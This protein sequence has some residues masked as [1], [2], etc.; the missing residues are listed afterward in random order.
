M[1][2]PKAP[3]GAH[4]SVAGG[5]HRCLPRADAIG[6]EVIQV[7]VANTRAWALPAADP[8]GDAQFRVSCSG[9]D[10]PVFVHA[11]YLINFGSPS[12]ETLAR[13]CSALAFSLRRAAAV[14]AAGVVLHAGS[15]V[16]GNGWGTA[17][18]QVREHVLPVLD[19]AAGAPPLLV[20]PTAG[21]GGALASDAASLAAYLDAL[22][23]DERVGVCLDTCHMHAA[24]H[25]LSTRTGFSAALRAYG[26]AAGRGGIGL[27][28]ANDSRDPAGSKR[29][30]HASIGTGSIGL[31]PFTALFTSP[32]T[33]SVPMVV[34]TLDTQQAADVATLKKLRAAAD[35]R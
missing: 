21:G 14:G 23:R 12:A 18:S 28:H 16:L 27:V 10:V 17:M 6:A 1:P 20:E 11:P 5:L 35:G 2:A 22:G 26:R 8:D 9:R 25:D 7:F 30:R 34:E 19:A 15:A 29:D 24:G 13:S 32:V 33:R 31:D 4:V 3:V